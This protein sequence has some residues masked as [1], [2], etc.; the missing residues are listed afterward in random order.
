MNH[1]TERILRNLVAL[2]EDDWQPE[3]WSTWEAMRVDA[4]GE[5]GR[6]DRARERNQADKARRA[7]ASK[8][9][10]SRQRNRANQ[11][12]RK[13]QEARAHVLHV[14]RRCCAGHLTP[15]GVCTGDA[16]EVHHLAGRAGDLLWDP[17]NLLAVCSACH[18]WISVHPA[19]ACDLG[20]MV[21][22]LGVNG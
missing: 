17:S 4:A 5:L 22:R 11:R 7:E 2:P 19:D 1:R 14:H 6:L 15:E 13:W 10:A 12:E 9:A 3:D 21:K 16:T 8:R 18:R 20:L